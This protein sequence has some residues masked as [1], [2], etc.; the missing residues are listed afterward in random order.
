MFDLPKMYE[1]WGKIGGDIGTLQRYIEDGTPMGGF[2]TSLFEGDLFEAVRK[3]DLNN[4]FKIPDFAGWILRYA[5]VRCYGNPEKVDYW[6]FKGGAKEWNTW[7]TE[8][9]A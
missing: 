9:S 8:V 3:A 1:E 5:P 7:L 2:Y 4:Y 6:C